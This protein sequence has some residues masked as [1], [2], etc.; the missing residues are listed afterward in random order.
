MISFILPVRNAI[1]TLEPVLRAV[2][3]FDGEPHELIVVDDGS[4]D[5]TAAIAEQHA[6]RVIRLDASHGPAEARNRAAE[7]AQGDILFFLD[8]DIRVTVPMIEQMVRLTR[9]NPESLGVSGATSCSPLNS[10]FFPRLCA[11]QEHFYQLEFVCAPDPAGFHY[12]NTRFGTLRKTDFDNVGRFNPDFRRPSLEDLEL[13][14]RL[15][16]IGTFIFASDVQVPH[17]W[18]SNIVALWRRYFRNS[19]LWASRIRPKTRRFDRVLA[20]GRRGASV[21]CGFGAL[22]VLAS[23]VVLPGWYRPAAIVIALFLLAAHVRLNWAM[24]RFFKQQS[25]LVFALG[26]AASILSY[27]VPITFGSTLGSLAYAVSWKQR[28]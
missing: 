21:L 8:S 13:S 6:T 28:T 9:E 11:Q 15:E 12:V 23:S 18:P 24:L 25:G 5:G 10:G 27:T 20:T 14:I 1:G 2:A 3:K 26:A 17:H 22:A 16:R 4:T 7:V 19:Y